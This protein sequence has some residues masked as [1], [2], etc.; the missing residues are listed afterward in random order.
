M[1]L[2]TWYWKLYT[3]WFIFYSNYLKVFLLRCS[4]IS[5]N[6]LTL[7]NACNYLNIFK[8]NLLKYSPDIKYNVVSIKLFWHNRKVFNLIRALSSNSYVYQQFLLYKPLS[9][10]IE[11]TTHMNAMIYVYIYIYSFSTTHVYSL[12]I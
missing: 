9:H 1:R 7:R 11:L 3:I 10:I 12:H 6:L 4:R 8:I 5:K 2:K